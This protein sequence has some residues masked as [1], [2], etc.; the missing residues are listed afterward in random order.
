MGIN[1]RG[2][3]PRVNAWSLKF[4]NYCLRFL[5]SRKRLYSVGNMGMYAFPSEFPHGCLGSRNPSL[6]GDIEASELTNEELRGPTSFIAKKSA[7][8][9]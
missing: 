9:S 2:G 4:G 8:A 7:G 6:S 1:S 3:V 5:R